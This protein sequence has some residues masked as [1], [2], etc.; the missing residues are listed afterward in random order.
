MTE[1]KRAIQLDN[2][3]VNSLHLLVLLLSAEKK[4]S[5][6]IDGHKC[7]QHFACSIKKPMMCASLRWNCHPLT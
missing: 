3:H 5:V 7:Y 2:C 6:A 4:V 1:I